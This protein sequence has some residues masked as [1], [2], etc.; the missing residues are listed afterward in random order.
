MSQKGLAN[1]TAGETALC[2]LGGESEELYYRGYN[3]C[4][5]ADKYSFEA[6]AF[7]LLKGHVP[8]KEEISTYTEELMLLADIPFEVEK[9][10][11]G[12][13]EDA[14]AM[15]VLRTGVSLLGI[16]E[17][18]NDDY[19]GL[20]IA[21]RLMVLLPRFLAIWRGKS[22]PKNASI[23]QAVCIACC[24]AEVDDVFVDAM[25]Q[26]LILYAEHEFNASTFAARVT[27]ATLSDM[28]SAIC[29]AIGTLR[30]PLH[31]GANEQALYL[32][33]SFD[34]VASVEE[35]IKQKLINKEKLMGF[36]HRV[37]KTKD[38]RS[39]KLY[40]ILDSLPHTDLFDIAKEIERTMM[41][42]KQLIS[43]VDFYTAVL[44]EQMNIK[45]SLFVAIFV[46]GR[47]AGWSAHVLEQRA[48]NRLIRPL[49][50]YIGP[51]PID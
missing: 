14:N 27:S 37:Y 16:F 34:D 7:L 4:K 41:D 25:N 19:H 30:G 44:Y 50:E 36:G 43:N 32:I 21:N 31:G 33:K 20:V 5:L 49:A 18:E 17:P 12:L 47:I 1:V 10:L 13:P 51:D 2:K 8:S 22:V 28:Y 48:N 26:S 40:S 3:A 29:S 38:P 11:R 45:P 42:E 15:D 39:H 6:V 46:F 35:G 9:T 23:A 24:D